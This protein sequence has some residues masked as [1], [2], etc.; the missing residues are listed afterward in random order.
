[1]STSGVSLLTTLLTPP[2][3]RRGDADRHLLE[4]A[5]LLLT[6]AR[7][8][9][10][11]SEHKLART[12]RA[13]IAPKNCG[14]RATGCAGNA[15]GKPAKME[16]RR[17]GACDTCCTWRATKIKQRQERTT[18]LHRCALLAHASAGDVPA[19]SNR[20]SD[21]AACSKRSVVA[22]VSRKWAVVIAH[23]GAPSRMWSVV[24]CP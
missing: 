12:R 13:P 11:F 19:I 1:M 8:R 10:K 5:Q 7:I 4:S 17:H 2:S 14:R 9:P 15:L 18:D 6:L 3:A 24:G 16:A 22:A 23:K 20:R 21:E